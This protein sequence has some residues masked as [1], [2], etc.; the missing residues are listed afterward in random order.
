MR[1]VIDLKE[2]EHFLKANLDLSDHFVVLMA[3]KF[4]SIYLL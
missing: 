2:S 3:C 1:A 4:Y